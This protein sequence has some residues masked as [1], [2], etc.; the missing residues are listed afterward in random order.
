LFSFP[1]MLMT[2]LFASPFFASLDIQ[3]GGPVLRDPDIWW[4]LRNAEILFSTHRFV[5]EDL[6]S[7]T[8]YG[9]PWINHEWLGE[10]PYYIGFRL[11]GE[12]GLFLVMLLAVELVIGG[13]LLLCY[14]HTGD[15]KAAFLATWIAVLLATINMGP[16]T[17]LFGWLCFIAELLLL[18]DFRKGRDHLWLLAPL[19]A[20]WINLHGSWFMGMAFFV[21][22]AASGLVRGTW[23]RI[24]AVRWT[25]QQMRTLAAVGGASVAMLFANPYGWRLVA[26]PLDMMFRQR[27]NVAVIDEWQSIDFQSFHGTMLFVLVGLIYVFTLAQQRRWPLHELLFALLA[28]YAALTHKRLL[29]LFGIVVCPIFAEELAGAVFAPFNPKHDKPLLNAVIM[30]ALCVFAVRHIPTS[31]TLRAA[32]AQYFPVAALT[33]QNGSCGKGHMLN[34][35][36]WGGYLIWNARKTPVFLDSRTDVFEYHGVLAD[37]LKAITMNDSLAIL[38]QYRINCVLLA[39]ETQMVYLLKHEPGWRV[40]HEDATAILMVRTQP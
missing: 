18:D 26:Y 10:V 8:T 2:A 27:L 35:Y 37:Y 39:P 29:F 36:E 31:A 3:Q 20:L 5:R 14:R 17:I 11:L 32:E 22:F 28:F 1:A 6:F 38:D 21:L 34:R 9:Q 13:V 40:Q 4:H 25:P 23:G 30:A 12:R 33:E 24:E 16:R 7:F 15:V 19:F